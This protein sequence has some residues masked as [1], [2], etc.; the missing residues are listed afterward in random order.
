MTRSQAFANR[1]KA[2]FR[3]RKKVITTA[4][5][6]AAGTGYYVL[7]RLTGLGLPC[8]FHKLTGLYCPGCGV[9]RMV[10]DAS[11]FDLAGAFSDNAA[12]LVMLPVWLVVLLLSGFRRND[13]RL[14]ETKPVKVLTFI[15]LGILIVFGIIRNLP[16]FGF[17]RP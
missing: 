11:R 8:L 4:V 13:V 16:G 9:T 5:L 12:V 17:L 10:V 7:Y 1:F 3:D 6:L 15:T 14:T 2:F